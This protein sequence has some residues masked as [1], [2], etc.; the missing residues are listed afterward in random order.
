MSAKTDFMSRIS[1]RDSRRARRGFSLVEVIVAT[2]LFGI[3]ATAIFAAYLFMGRNLTR[4]VSS[5]QQQVEARRTLRTFTQDLSAAISVSTASSSQIVF[6]KPTATST[7]TITYTYSSANG[8][9]VRTEASASKTLLTGLTS[10]TLN[11][12]N[13]VGTAVPS[14]PQSIKSVEIVFS[15]AAGT[16][17]SGTES[18]YTT[19]SPRVLLRNKAALQ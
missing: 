16:A 11:Y 19:V 10:F 13:Q 17:T 15:S 5:Q 4:L 14:S 7:T 6:T 2:S 9:L 8:T 1:V 3:V 18:A 12:Y